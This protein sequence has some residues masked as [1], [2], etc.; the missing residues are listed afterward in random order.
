MRTKESRKS[1]AEQSRVQNREP[2]PVRTVQTP[3]GPREIP[4]NPS[5]IRRY[6]NRPWTGS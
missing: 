3:K 2:L 6:R 5:A 4:W 1:F